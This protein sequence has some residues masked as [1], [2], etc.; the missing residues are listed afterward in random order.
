[1][2]KLVLQNNKKYA[3]VILVTNL[4]IINYNYIIKVTHNKTFFDLV[5]MSETMEGLKNRS[6]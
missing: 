5:L 6:L 2:V 4:H 3:E 1:M